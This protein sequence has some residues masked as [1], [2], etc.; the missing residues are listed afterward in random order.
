MQT[1]ERTHN[2]AKVF[3]ECAGHCSTCQPHDGRMVL[4]YNGLGGKAYYT[5][6]RTGGRTMTPKCTSNIPGSVPHV[7]L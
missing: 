1:Y 6:G 2:D 7:S 5:H 4:V 3:V